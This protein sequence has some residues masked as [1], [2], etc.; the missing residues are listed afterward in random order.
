MELMVSVLLGILG[1]V[2]SVIVTIKLAHPLRLSH[3]PQ[4]PKKLPRTRR[5]RS[6]SFRYGLY[7]V[8]EYADAV[9]KFKPSNGDQDPDRRF[10]LEDLRRWGYQALLSCAS[11]IVTDSQSKANLFRVTAVVLNQDGDPERF[12]LGSFEFVGPFPLAQVS[13]GGLFREFSSAEPEVPVSIR[14]VNQ[15]RI[16][17]IRLNL[18]EMNRTE[19][20]LGTTHSLGIPI[21]ADASLVSRGRVASIVVD[22]RM[23]KLKQA[24][25]NRTGF[26]EK[27]QL[28]K[29]AEALQESARRLVAA[30]NASGLGE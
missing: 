16:R 25:Y 1:I 19:H 24:L 9:R 23:G 18:D 27:S 22:L 29:R 2:I 20:D 3:E 17:L 14:V 6:K 13:R 28:M 21:I 12:D 11:S 8:N 15:D 7:L 26:F 5:W 4:K 30:L 10:Q